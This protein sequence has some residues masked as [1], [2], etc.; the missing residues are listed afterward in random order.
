[1]ERHV[2]RLNCDGKEVILI[3]TAHISQ[4]SV[5]QV[6]QIIESEQPDA[7]CVELDHQ[8]YFALTAEADQFHKVTRLKKR[9]DLFFSLLFSRLQKRLADSLDVRPGQE[10]IQAI[11]SAESCGA[12]VIF[13]DRSAQITFRRIWKKLT[14]MEKIKLI[15]QLLFGL[16][17][18]VKISESEIEELK[19]QDTLASLLSKFGRK[20]PQLKKTLIDERD[21]YLAAKIMEAPGGKV[22]AVVGAAH[23]P[24]IAEQIHSKKDTR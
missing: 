21:Q 12:A 23:V 18:G 10:M 3:G 16:I 2:T 24:G 22:I 13:A 5:E 14:W 11:A 20:F 19:S 1:M 8:R 17:R 9:P 6:K 4:R 15:A 7:V